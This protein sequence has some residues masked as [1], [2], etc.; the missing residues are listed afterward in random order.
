MVEWIKKVWY[1]YTMKYYV[2]L[3]RESVEARFT[4]LCNID[5]PREFY[6]K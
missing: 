2:V 1:I 3:I 4:V 5:V 6:V